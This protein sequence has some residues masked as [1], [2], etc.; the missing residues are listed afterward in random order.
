MKSGN[1]NVV[2]LNSNKVKKGSIDIMGK[3]MKVLLIFWG[4]ILV[5]IALKFL[6]S[7]RPNKIDFSISDYVN[8]DAISEILHLSTSDK[9]DKV[10]KE[11]ASSTKKV[12]SEYQVTYFSPSKDNCLAN[13]GKIYL[14]TCHTEWINAKKICEKES[15]RLPTV[16]ELKKEVND[17]GIEIFNSQKLAEDK[18]MEVLLKKI[19]TNMANTSYRKCYEEKGFIAENIYWTSDV[20]E[21]Y[22]S[23]WRISINEASLGLNAIA[24]D[25][26]SNVVCVK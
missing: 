25:S 11:N 7:F 15:G 22:T 1:H 8:T 19:Q 26:N 14:N 18:G 12:S 5:S 21:D 23:A 6:S 17:C 16:K 9:K 13:G 3:L 2:K 20:N 24:I 4:I 10:L